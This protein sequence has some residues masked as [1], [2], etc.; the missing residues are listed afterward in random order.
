M[1]LSQ[2]DIQ[3]LTKL[4]E[5]GKSMDESLGILSQVR[6]K[7][8]M[9]PKPI[10]PPETKGERL[11]REFKEGASDISQQMQSTLETP[12]FSGERLD[13]VKQVG[14]TA[15]KGVGAVA[16][17]A[18]EAVAKPLQNLGTELGLLFSRA[19][20]EQKD[21]IRADIMRE[22]DTASAKAEL[23]E[24]GS[25]VVTGATALMP[26][27]KAVKAI[28]AGGGI[29]RS[30]GAG[31]LSGL[32]GTVAQQVGTEGELPTLGEAAIGTASGAIVGGAIGGVAKGVDMYKNRAVREALDIAQR[33]KDIYK[34]TTEILQPPKQAYQVENLKAGES[35]RSI[36]ATAQVI[37]EAKSLPE[38]E[39]Q[40][41]KASD[42]SIG[43]VNNAIQEN[44]DKYVGFDY[45]TKLQNT[46]S[47]IA[48]DPTKTNIANKMQQILDRE[49]EWARRVGTPDQGIPLITAQAR[50]RQI[51][52]DIQKFFSKKDVTDLEATDLQA[53]NLIRSGL[54]DGIEGIIGKE[55]GDAN[56]LYGNLQDAR[57]F[58]A[59][60]DQRY[61]RE[62]TPTKLQ[63]LME[64]IP[65]IRSFLKGSPDRVIG[66]RSGQILDEGFFGDTMLRK[67]TKEI[68]KMRK[69]I[70]AYKAKQ[71]KQPEKPYSPTVLVGKQDP[72]KREE[73][74]RIAKEKSQ[75]KRIEEEAKIQALQKRMEAKIELNK[76]EQQLRAL[77][78]MKLQEQGYTLGKDFITKPV[79]QTA[80]EVAQS[81]PKP[82]VK[83]E[84]KKKVPLKKEEVTLKQNQSFNKA[85]DTTDP[86]NFKSAE[87]FVKADESLQKLKFN[88]A[89]Y[90]KEGVD[91]IALNVGE[92]E[93]NGKDVVLLSYIESSLKNKGIGSKIVE[94][95][96]IYADA[97]QKPLVITNVS[98]NIFWDSFPF[99]EKNVWGEYVYNPGGLKP[100]SRKPSGIDRK[101]FLGETVSMNGKKYKIM[102]I[103]ESGN[104][105]LAVD[106]I[107]E[108]GWTVKTKSQ[109]TDIWNKEHNK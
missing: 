72:A 93:W 5:Q 45:L 1:A 104:Y 67:R 57:A 73:A 28:G 80:K 47:R 102:D 74:I 68:E 86:R 70:E 8:N 77:E 10:L 22:V 40:L 21:Q 98:N 41:V 7:L 58:L 94:R 39:S 56:R 105:V 79:P 50:K 31:A 61:M 11:Q 64:K 37:K 33:E 38:V 97:K 54:M 4:K 46:V 6:Q 96:K 36:K 87:Q 32:E 12:R 76:M 17:T 95:L 14:K 62:I 48:D 30:A 103:T 52:D 63:K 88:Q 15:L 101:S 78:A 69:Q 3:F 20:P 60:V 99:F 66:T 83:A 106:G 92:R 81:I 51:G 82:Q 25:T 91:D 59:N 42:E 26:A 84:V 53:R 24:A 108:K 29:L 100:F 27:S 90:F 43:K 9:Q 16:Q 65:Y 55:A 18:G 34:Y 35:P 107:K 44:A 109:L 49:M 19:T 23:S 85:V 2:Q 71:P 89:K 75:M 13:A